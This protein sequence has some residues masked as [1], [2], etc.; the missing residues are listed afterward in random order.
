M[1]GERAGARNKGFS[2]RLGDED[3][4][5]EEEEMEGGPPPDAAT[6]AAAASSSSSG[7]GV[8]SLA[9]HGRDVV[10]P[11]APIAKHKVA[12]LMRRWSSGSRQTART[13]HPPAAAAVTHSIFSGDQAPMCRDAVRDT[14]PFASENQMFSPDVA[15]TKKGRAARDSS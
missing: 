2:V 14:F 1:P 10:P 3:V 13:A 12:R 7:R 6:V 4:E 15:N 5:E 11:C 8:G 9:F